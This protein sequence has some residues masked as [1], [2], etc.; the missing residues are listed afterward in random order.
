MKETQYFSHNYNARNDGKLELLLMRKWLAGIGAYW[1]ILEML[2]EEN[3]YLMQSQCERIAFAL[4]VE[5]SFIKEVIFEYDLFSYDEEQF[6]SK[7]ALERI[8]L[9][10]EKSTKAR[11]SAENR[12]NKTTKDANALRPQSDGNAIKEIKGKEIK[13]KETDTADSQESDESVFFDSNFWNKYPKKVNKKDTQRRFFSLSKLDRASALAGLL[14]YVEYWWREKTEIRFIPA[15]DVWINKRKWEDDLSAPSVWAYT[16]PVLDEANKKRKEMADAEVKKDKEE[17]AALWRRY[18]D[19]EPE[20]QIEI[21]K[22]AEEKCANFGVP[23]GKI[24]FEKIHSG[25]IMH[26]FRERKGI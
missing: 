11:A 5:E 19:L 6:W 23:R 7:S 15:P 21:E 2:Y 4:R 12:W 16:K 25:Q 20:E 13:E 9:R 17:T 18:H 3:G 26:I 22:L 24:W 8:S 14:K 10:N 1:C